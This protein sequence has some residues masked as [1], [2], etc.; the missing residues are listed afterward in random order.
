MPAQRSAAAFALMSCPTRSE[1]TSWPWFE[2]CV[3]SPEAC[4]TVWGSLI[5]GSHTTWTAWYW[6]PFDILSKALPQAGNR[7]L[8]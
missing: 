1:G 7:R 3:K 8:K 5:L 4:L 2:Q 6:G